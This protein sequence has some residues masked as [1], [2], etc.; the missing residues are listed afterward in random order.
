MSQYWGNRQWYWYHL[1]SYTSPDT[2]GIPVKKFYRDFIYLMTK[3][4]PCEKCYGH[5]KLYLK[6]IINCIYK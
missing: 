4:I 6:V 5:F 3:L 2:L 1:V